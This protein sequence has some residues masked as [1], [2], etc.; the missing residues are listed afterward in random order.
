M[1]N[2]SCFE[3]TATTK[4]PVFFKD[5]FPQSLDVGCC[6]KE[7]CGLDQGNSLWPR[8]ILHRGD[9]WGYLHGTPSRWRDKPLNAEEGYG[10]CNYTSISFTLL[11]STTLSS[12][13]I[14]SRILEWVVR[15]GE[16]LLRE[17]YE[18]KV[19]PS[20]T[21]GSRVIADTHYFLPLQ[22]L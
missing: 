19:S 10:Q 5:T 22:S 18:R 15:D 8:Q 16:I 14:S 21:A 20:T 4:K 11:I 6:R 12:A 17:T 2:T 1:Q 3:D 13:S 9:T 7:A